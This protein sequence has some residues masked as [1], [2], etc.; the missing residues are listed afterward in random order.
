METNGGGSGSDPADLSRILSELE[1]LKAAKSDIDR[2]IAALGNQLRDLT[3]HQNDRNDAVS[4]S[5]PLISAVYS[6]ISHDLMPDAVYRY[7]RQLLLPSFGVQGTGNLIFSFCELKAQLILI[8][9][10]IYLFLCIFILN[11]D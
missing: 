9:A 4:S 7:S 8:I 5:C 3:A 10:S 1:T 11:L 6:N 2:R